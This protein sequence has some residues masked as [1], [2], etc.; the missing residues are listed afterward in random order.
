[1][2]TNHIIREDFEKQHREHIQGAAKNARLLRTVENK[3]I[4][5]AKFPAWEITLR[6][7]K[8]IR[9]RLLPTGGN[10]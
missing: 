5:A 8:A 1:M 6:K 2:F 3:P 9:L 10:L 4:R 7:F